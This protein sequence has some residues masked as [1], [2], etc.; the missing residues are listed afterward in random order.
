MYNIILINFNVLCD[1]A[2]QI[3]SVKKKTVNQGDK[4][5]KEPKKTQSFFGQHKIFPYDKN[6]I[7]N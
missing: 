6:K 3:G 4:F 7:K 5:E 2:T 1:K